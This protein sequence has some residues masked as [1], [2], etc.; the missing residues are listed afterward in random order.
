M[1]K[2]NSCRESILVNGTAALRKE[3]TILSL[4]S[5]IGTAPVRPVPASALSCAWLSWYCRNCSATSC[6]LLLHFLLPL[7]VTGW[8]YM[9]PDDAP[10]QGHVH[11]A[12]TTEKFSNI[13]NK[14]LALK[15]NH[16]LRWA[17]IYGRATTM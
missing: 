10:F 8:R 14:A 2:L 1:V 9:V 16:S 15:L 3:V 7:L 11:L 12:R 13:S 5:S 17:S 6:S 4:C